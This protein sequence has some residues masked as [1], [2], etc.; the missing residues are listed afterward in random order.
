ML[1][2][3]ILSI[4]SFIGTNIDDFIHDIF[5]NIYDDDWFVVCLGVCCI[6]STTFRKNNSEI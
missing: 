5:Y 6:E 2:I 4:T 3:L 1:E